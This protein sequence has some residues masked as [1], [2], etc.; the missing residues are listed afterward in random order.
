MKTAQET[1]DTVV[2]HLASMTHRSMDNDE[3]CAYRSADGNSCA[4]GCLITDEEYTRDIEG[5]RVYAASCLLPDFQNEYR[6]HLDMLM[7]LQRI[8]DDSKNWTTVDRV[9]MRT[10]LKELGLR[11][12]VDTSIVD[13]VTF[14]P[15]DPS[16]QSA[17][18]DH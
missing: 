6:D 12:F 7:F 15:I 5:S 9:E 8:H 11:S 17:S 4:V 16:V 3:V 13:K 18:T 14:V 10:K 2:T 1:F